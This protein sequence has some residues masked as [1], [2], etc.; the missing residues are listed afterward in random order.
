MQ[1]AVAIISQVTIERRV[2]MVHSSLAL[3]TLNVVYVVELIHTKEVVLL[4]A[5]SEGTVAN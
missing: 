1:L 4:K 3:A 2:P 5:K